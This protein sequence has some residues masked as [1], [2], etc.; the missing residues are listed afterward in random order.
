MEFAAGT[1]FTNPNL[2]E[3]GPRW[4]AYYAAVASWTQQ[5]PVT[6][7]FYLLVGLPVRVQLSPSSPTLTRQ[8]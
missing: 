4:V 7:L 5:N 3:V 1:I 8:T 2:P 6:G